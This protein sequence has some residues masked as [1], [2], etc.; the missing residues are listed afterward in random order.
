[1]TVTET[2]PE[3][4]TSQAAQPEPPVDWAHRREVAERKLQTL[5]RAV[6]GWR[7]R[8]PETADAKTEEYIR[9][10]DSTWRDQLRAAGGG[11]DYPF[12][13]E[14]QRAQAAEAAQPIIMV[15]TVRRQLAGEYCG[16]GPRRAAQ[17]FEI[18]VPRDGYHM[19]WSVRF[20]VESSHFS[21]TGRATPTEQNRMIEFG[22][23]PPEIPLPKG[24]TIQEGSWTV[25]ANGGRRSYENLP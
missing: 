14:Q 19:Q 13:T 17:V 4:E 20:T 18:P 2:R 10:I 3:Q 24:F 5:R 23:N 9:V 16:E 15:E 1:M 12:M 25:V 22:S 8:T 6:Y 21:T 7:G 11:V